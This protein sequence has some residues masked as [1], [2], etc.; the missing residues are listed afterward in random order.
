MPRYFK[1]S[2]CEP[3]LGEIERALRE[4]IFHKAEYQK[5]DGEMEASLERI[6]ALGGARV[7]PGAHLAL[8]ARRDTSVAALRSAIAEIESMGAMVKDVDIG[9]IDFLSTYRGREVCLCW[10]LGE[11]RIRF[12]HGTEEG[13]KGRKEID[14]DFLAGHGEGEE[15]PN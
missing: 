7:N 15:H 1:L 12:W 14:E 8:R 5:A 2:E 6:R 11:D 9:L 13:F 4:A 3:L 10:K